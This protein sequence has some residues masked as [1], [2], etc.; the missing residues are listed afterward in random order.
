MK[1]KFFKYWFWWPIDTYDNYQSDTPPVM[2]LDRNI[3]ATLVSEYIDGKE[4]GILAKKWVIS[5]DG[6][7][8]TFY[9]RTDLKFDDGTPITPAIVL[10]NFKRILWL[11][12]K[13]GL[14]LNSLLPEVSSWKNMN[15]K[16]NVI[17]LKNDSQL[18]FKFSRRPIG[19]FSQLGQPIYSVVSPKCFSRNGRWRTP[20][21]AIASGQYSV[22]G[23][24]KNFIDLKSRG[25]FKTVKNSPKFVRIEW[26]VRSGDSVV[27]AIGDGRADLTVEHSF[28]LSKKTLVTLRKESVRTIYEPPVRMHFVD[29]NAKRFPFNN[30]TLRQKFRDLFLYKLSHDRDFLSSGIKVN[31]SFIPRGGVGYEY[32]P[33]PHIKVKEK[34]RVIGTAEVLLYPLSADPKIQHAIDNCVIETLRELGIEP[35]IRRYTDRFV[36]FNKMRRGKF[37]VMV[38][39]TGILVNNPYGDLRM[40]FMSKIGANIPDPSGQIPDLIRKAEVEQN[41]RK[42][43]GL[44]KKINQIMFNDASIITFAHSSLVYLYRGKVNFRHYN[45]FEDPIEFRAIGWQK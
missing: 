28:G 30:K 33:I 12:R 31:D 32:F 17:F 16:S 5:T 7:T 8:W 23:R 18:V 19:L 26:P 24:G 25:I 39:G 45:L 35:K 29:L 43:A 20:Y 27:K 1:P 38:R 6:R 37:D 44:V 36:P 2:Q 10:L 15:S 40:M 21:C 13:S 14:V 3:Y 9:L 34:S 4:E 11:T 22:I 42:R 41:G